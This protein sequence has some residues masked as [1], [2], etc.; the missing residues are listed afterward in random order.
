MR[1]DAAALLLWLTTVLCAQEGAPPAAA[2]AAASGLEAA[3]A[4]A[5]ANRGQL[6]QA[7]AQASGEQHADLAFLVEHM[8]ESDLRTLG[9]EFLL[10]DTKLAR[11]AL[12]SAPWAASIPADVYREAVLPYAQ[13]DEVR[14]PWRARLRELSLPL[15]AGAKTAGEAAL[16]LNEKLFGV[17][18]VRYSTKRRK[19]CQSPSES[20]EQG[21]AS[22]TGLSILLA[23]ACRSVGVPAR[24]AGI[25]LWPAAGDQPAGGNHTW[26]EVWDGSAWR[27]RGTA[28]RAS[29]ARGS[30]A[31]RARRWPATRAARSAP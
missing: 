10:A 24:I 7:L 3:L 8:P 21:L 2:P 27:R 5:G 20:I 6:E 15:V 1:I 11:E 28:T 22:C 13:A 18:N 17:V 16:R 4:R 26:V 14:E 9:A 31:A 30:P 29:T 25:A 12:E 23:D 19:A